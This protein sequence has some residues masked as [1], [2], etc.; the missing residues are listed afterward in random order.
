[1]CSSRKTVQY[2][3]Q[4]PDLRQVTRSLVINMQQ[5]SVTT[6][7]DIAEPRDRTIPTPANSLRSY[8]TYQAVMAK[9]IRETRVI[10]DRTK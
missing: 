4:H 5:R 2:R 7:I 8:G 9:A 3:P 10:I 6:T 1:M